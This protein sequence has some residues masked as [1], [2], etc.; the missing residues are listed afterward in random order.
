[1][2]KPPAVC[3]LAALFLEPIWNTS[4]CGGKGGQGKRQGV[5][6]GRERRAKQ[7]GGVEVGK[8]RAARRCAC[9]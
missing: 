1:M 9:E 6:L 2:E 5:S 3:V 4:A 8:E 7:N